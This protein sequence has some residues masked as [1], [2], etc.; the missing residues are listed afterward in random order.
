MKVQGRQEV[1]AHTLTYRQQ[2]KV[3]HPVGIATP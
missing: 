3:D 2:G 1:S